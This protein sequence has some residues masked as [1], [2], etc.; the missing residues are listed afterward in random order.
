VTAE[1][2]T[3]WII[4]S[5]T[6]CG[7]PTALSSPANSV[8]YQYEPSPVIWHVVAVACLNPTSHF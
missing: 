4:F 7:I 5:T 2:Y 8:S 3:H 6:S 1:A